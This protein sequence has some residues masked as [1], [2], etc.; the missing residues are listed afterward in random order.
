[1]K[2]ILI[3]GGSG[4]IGR[5]LVEKLGSKYE[6][7]A[8]GHKDLELLDENAVSDFFKRNN[9]DVVIHGAVKPGH[10]NAK[11]TCELLKNNIRIFFNVARNSRLIGKMLYL[12]SGS[13]YD[14]RHYIPKMKEDYFDVHVPSDDTGLSK[15]VAA[16]YIENSSNITELRIF[17]I[18]GKYEDYAIRFISNMICKAIFDLP[19]T[20]HQNRKFDYL[21]VSDL[22]EILNFFIEKR[23]KFRAYN[24]TPDRS[25][26]LYELAKM[27]LEI[28]RKSLPIVVA[29]EGVGLEYSGDNTR[30]KKEIKGLK[31]TDI[32]Q[33]I[34]ELYDWYVAHK[35]EINREVLL[36]DK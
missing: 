29:K 9:I 11:D 35:S 14:M 17:G 13:V 32:K 8:P 2:K 28:S 21:Y 30:I 19:L 4:F 36:T 23:P 12:S 16:K 20:M 33:A 24:L 22:P 10:R 27:V 31:F 7:L 26:E 1:M 15:Y 3:T 6:I 18:F 25:I 5:N 34:K